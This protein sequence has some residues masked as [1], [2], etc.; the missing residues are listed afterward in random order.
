MNSKNGL[1]NGVW[2][3]APEVFDAVNMGLTICKFVV[4]MLNPMMLFITQVN[5][6][7]I[8]FPPIGVDRAFKIHL[9]PDHRL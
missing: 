5:Q 8:A 2:S 9:T 4:A 1:N 6:A 3:D 7:V